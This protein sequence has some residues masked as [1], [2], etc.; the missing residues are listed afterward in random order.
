MI[1][2]RHADPGPVA[3]SEDVRPHILH[4]VTSSVTVP[5]MRGQLRALQE[6]GFRVTVGSDPGEGLT[7]TADHDGAEAAVVPMTREISP[8]QDLR[9]LWGLWRLLR[10]LRPTLVNAGTAKAGL[11]GGIAAWLAGVPCRVYT[12]HGLRLE[13]TRGWKRR[14]LLVTERLA[15]R[16]AHRVLCVSHSARQRTLDLGLTTPEKAVVLGAGS[17]NGIELGR[18]APTPERLVRARELRAELGIPHDAPVIGFVGRFVRDKG[19]PELVAAFQALCLHRP[20]ARLLLIGQYESGD[21]VPEATRRALEDD[22]HIVN[23]GYQPD[24]AP[25]YHVMDLL[26]LPSYREGFPTVVLEAAAAARPVVATCATGCTDA[27][28]DGATGL[29][30]PVGDSAALAE[31]LRAL[32]DDPAQARRL[33]RAGRDRVCRDFG[34]PQ[35]WEHLAGFYRELLAGTEADPALVAFSRRWGR[36]SRGAKR[37]GDMVGALLGLAVAAPVLAAAA[38]LIRLTMGSPV[39]FRQRRTGRYGRSFVLAKFRTMHMAR[40]AQGRLLTDV[41]RLT[42]VGRL[43]R[44]LSIDELPQLWHVLAGD[45]SLVGPRPLLP[46]YLPAYTPRERLRH[47]VRPGLTGCA[48]VN[49]RHTLPFSKRLALD[50]WYVE[51]W[52]L[53]LD[54]RILLVT[55][56]RALRGRELMVCQDLLEVDDRGLWRHLTD[57]QPGRGEAA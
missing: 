35:V 50:T 10:R 1:R 3:A 45:M 12:V 29:L 39:L 31:A 53:G 17:F 48:Q 22:P 56:P 28:V 44:R 5:L 27:V 6:A 14:I 55:L 51:Q 33:G 2:S 49:G 46:E 11:L 24:P 57:I 26:V 37:A 34:Q 52:S 20:D 13:T 15:C 41:E 23:L 9:S 21:P 43:L 47:A 30:V 25:Y 19:I 7:A 18:F 32:V 4:L 42:P 54:L 40:D 36:A 8:L 38:V 16:C